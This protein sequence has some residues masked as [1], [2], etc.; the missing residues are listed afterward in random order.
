M[1]YNFARPN[2][3]V[4]YSAKINAP[5]ETLPLGEK[6]WPVYRDA[7]I[8]FGLTEGKIFQDLS[9]VGSDRN[10]QEEFAR[11]G[12]I[13][14]T[15]V[16]ATIDESQEHFHAF[17]KGAKLDYLVLT[18]HARLSRFSKED[19]SALFPDA[20]Y[21][22]VQADPNWDSFGAGGFSEEA[23]QLIGGSTVG[24]FLP[25]FG[26]F[27]NMS[28]ALIIDSRLAATQSD[29]GRIVNN[30]DTTFGI[31]RQLYNEPYAASALISKGI[32]QIGVMHV[33]ELIT[34]NPQLF[35]P[36]QL[37]HLQQSV[38]QFR[39]PTKLGFARERLVTQD[40]LQRIY[41]DDGNGDGRLT[42]IGLKILT[43]LKKNGQ[44][45]ITRRTHR[46]YW[47]R[48]SNEPQQHEPCSVLL[49]C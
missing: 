3:A 39:I 5:I 1:F 33:K 46:T 17:R 30:V 44:P 22:S 9:V 25:H 13:E 40:I 37:E 15:K 18:M 48:G 31:A 28:H 41:S 12:D 34:N 42:P 27:Y 49:R 29:S 16:V 19:F 8:K 10:S 36:A 45:I 47:F 26:A 38:A 11:P 4:N 6:A 20:D 32:F 35:D 14:W 2:V 43:M 23:D 24:I 7:W 21:A